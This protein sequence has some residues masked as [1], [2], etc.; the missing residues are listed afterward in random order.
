LFL[1][2]GIVRGME[3]LHSRRPHPVIHGDLKLRNVLVGQGFVA[4]VCV[5]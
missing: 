1:A 5:L 3:Y 2:H 4:K